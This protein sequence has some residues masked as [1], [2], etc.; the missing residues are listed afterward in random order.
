MIQGI[1]IR[2]SGS[3][4]PPTPIPPHDGT[5]TACQTPNPPW[6]CNDSPDAIIDG[7]IAIL[8]IIGIVLGI[9]VACK[10]KKEN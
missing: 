3:N 4:H 1:E 5:H 6:W 10:M 8:M 9:I 7:G 2:Q